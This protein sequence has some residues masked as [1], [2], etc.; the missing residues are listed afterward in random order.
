MGN[1]IS[2]QTVTSSEFMLIPYS[3]AAGCSPNGGTPTARPG[4]DKTAYIRGFDKFQDEDSV[5]P[6]RYLAEVKVALRMSFSDLA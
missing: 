2:L 6:H 3:S 4:S 5:S 1:A